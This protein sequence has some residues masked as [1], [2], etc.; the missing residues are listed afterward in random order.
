M[1]SRN[2]QQG[3]LKSVCVLV[4]AL[5][6]IL[7]DTNCNK[8]IACCFEREMSSSVFWAFSKYNSFYGGLYNK[9]PLFVDGPPEV[10]SKLQY[11]MKCNQVLPWF[12]ELVLP[13][14]VPCIPHNSILDCPQVPHCTTVSLHSCRIRITFPYELSQCSTR[15][16]ALLDA[17][18]LR[19]LPLV[20]MGIRSGSERAKVSF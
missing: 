17:L 4:I 5:P 16:T 13:K 20:S 2:Q 12:S 8:Y 15:C 14:T 18:P 11:H 7:L 19:W 3:T 10:L 6:Y 9:A 1:N